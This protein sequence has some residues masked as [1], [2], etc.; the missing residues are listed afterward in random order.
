M[1]IQRWDKENSELTKKTPRDVWPNS[2]TNLLGCL[3]M[4]SLVRQMACQSFVI[5][6]RASFYIKQTSVKANYEH[7]S[8]YPKRLGMPGHNNYQLCKKIGVHDDDVPL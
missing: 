4:Y 2:L 5:H 7:I 8:V 1:G 3:K 6:N